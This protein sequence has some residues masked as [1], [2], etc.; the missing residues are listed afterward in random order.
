MASMRAAMA[1][2]IL[3]IHRNGNTV[4]HRLAAHRSL[5][6]AALGLTVHRIAIPHSMPELGPVVIIMRQP[7]LQCRGSAVGLQQG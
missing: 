6:G 2:A 3:C 7:R 4:W 5:L 1:S